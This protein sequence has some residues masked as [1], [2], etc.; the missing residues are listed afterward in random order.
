MSTINYDGGT[1]VHIRQESGTLQYK[2]TTEPSWHDLSPSQIDVTNQT[3]NI[4][5]NLLK[6]EFI[7]DI[8]LN[9]DFYFNCSSSHI[10]FGSSSLKSDGTRPIITVNVPNYEG[11]IKN[12]DNGNTGYNNIHIYN[13]VINGSG[14]TLQNGAGWLCRQYF[15]KGAQAPYDN[16]IVNCSSSGNIN[17]A[18]SGGILGSY[19][20]SNSSNILKIIGCSSSG[21]AIGTGAGCGVVARPGRLAGR[22]L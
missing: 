2:S 12:G 16:Y 5:D 8:T 1:T 22:T 14:G 11:F 15:G 3:A 20:S 18:E 6:L 17:S 7:T 13:L 10:Q 9:D 19:A 4:N 21:N